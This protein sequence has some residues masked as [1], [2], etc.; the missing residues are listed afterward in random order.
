MSWLKSF[1]TL[2]LIL[3]ALIFTVPARAQFEVSPDHF[4][5]VAKNE[6]SQKS[7]ARTHAG[8]HPKTSSAVADAT[9]AAVSVRRRQNAAPTNQAGRTLTPKMTAKAKTNTM[10]AAAT[11]TLA[12]RTA[13]ASKEAT[14]STNQH[15]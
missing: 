10:Y 15:E 6:T 3:V 7:K 8:M 11:T 5:A 2:G 14:L 13:P 12:R 1:R 9:G 4:D